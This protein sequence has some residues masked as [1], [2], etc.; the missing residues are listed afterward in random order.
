[1][2]VD[3]SQFF[4]VFFEESLENLDTMESGLMQLGSGGTDHEIINGVFRAAH[5]IKGGAATFGFSAVADFTHVLE[6][7]LDKMRAGEHI[8]D[9][10]TVDLLLASVDSLRTMLSALQAGEV[11]NLLDHAHV[12]AGIE[13]L[14]SGQGAAKHEDVTEDLQSQQAGSSVPEP[15]SVATAAGWKISFKPHAEVLRTGNEP[16]RMF[17][18]L[19][20]LGELQ[21][22][23]ELANLPSFDLMHPEDCYLNWTLELRSNCTKNEVEEVFEWVCDDSDIEIVALNEQLPAATV[24]GDLQDYIQ[25]SLGAAVAVMP[26]DQAHADAA[27]DVQPSTPTID[28]HPGKAIAQ[29]AAQLGAQ[30]AVAKAS[31]DN[32]IRVSIEKID[33]LIN[34]VGELVITQ[35]MLSQLGDE[36][37]SEKLPNLLQGLGQLK[38]NTRELQ[39]S[40]MR[41]RMLPISFVFSRFPRMVRD[42]S[43]KLSKKINLIVLG[44]QTELD[45]TVMEKIGDPLVHL[46]RNSVDHGIETAADRLAASKSEVGSI[47]LN[48]YHQGGNVVIEVVDDGGGLKRDRILAKA[49]TNGL[50]P[51][52]AQLSDEQVFDFIFHPGFSTANEV[53]ELSGRGVGLD[54]V[55]RNINEL[56]G[57]IEVASAPGKGCKFTIRLPLTLAILDGQ[58]VRIGSHTYVFPLVSIVESLQAKPSMINRVAKGS[59]VLRLREEYVPLIKLNELFNIPADYRNVEDGLVVV[60]ESD[61]RKVGIVVDELLAQQQVV[62]KSLEN[63]YR[64]VDGVSG[65]TILG[66]GTV[67]LILDI[68]GLVKMAGVPKALD[69][70]LILP[71]TSVS[72]RAA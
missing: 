54:V 34:M 8:A 69:G 25:Q 52:G 41:I 9:A 33:Q 37:S 40:V 30:A 61:N 53:S 42:L 12:K 15:T 71:E 17:R 32:S 46:V 21:V 45:K 49:V 36:F 55:R 62:I 44:E 23:A 39:E 14:L 67:S 1:M 18:E 38:H 5:S 65:A 16:V 4:Q 35:S 64:R 63:N 43:A 48:A 3:L 27:Q 7:L 47:T 20:E 6:T 19:T 57:T 58:L 72:M 66:N 70:R 31:G 29:S 60:V 10:A 56:N 59:E 68:V 51:E 24:S 26:A 2:A 11:I 22:T 50:I 13:R 28:A